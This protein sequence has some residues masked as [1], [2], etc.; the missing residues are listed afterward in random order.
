[1]KRLLVTGGSGLVGA[2]LI[3]LAAARGWDVWATYH[4]RALTWP[5]AL[6][7]DL[8]DFDSTRAVVA[9]TR[10]DVVIHTACSN[11]S[12]E[13]IAAIGSAA[14]RLA[15]LTRDN[16]IRFIH[17]S[18]DLVF[19][20]EHPPYAD[21]SPPAPIMP[22]GVAKAE[23]EK[24]VAQIYPAALIVRPALIW[25][26]DPLDHQNKWIVDSARSGA[27]I[28]LFTDEYRTPVHLADL[29]AALLELAERPEISGV[30]NLVGPQSLNRWDFGLKVLAA[31]GLL[32]GPNIVPGTVK[33]SGLLRARNVSLLATR[34][35][36]EL[37]T[38][39]RS[40]D[41][42]LTP[43]PLSRRR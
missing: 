2:P 7:L 4:T 21:D 30:M 26:L 19:D 29:C 14:R 16:Q 40:V 12:A 23:A 31:L 9:E 15:Q 18:S 8:N 22:Y 1:M 13:Q 28:T 6:R 36:R 11:R 38:K 41:E 20:G 27:P 43:L 17:L 42:A 24:I 32:P 33:A 5:Q 35:Q 39:L 3:D 10:P 25:S 34:A 37:K